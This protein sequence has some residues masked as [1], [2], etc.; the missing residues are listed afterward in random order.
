ITDGNDGKGVTYND[1]KGAV[2]EAGV[3]LYALAVQSDKLTTEVSTLAQE[4][5]GL[6]AS[7]DTATQLPQLATNMAPTIGGLYVFSYQSNNRQRV[8]ALFVTVDNESVK[9]SFVAGSDA[10]GEESLTYIPSES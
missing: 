10:R 9:S 8:T 6:Y 1:A 5:G 4:S 3:P 7:T 2:I